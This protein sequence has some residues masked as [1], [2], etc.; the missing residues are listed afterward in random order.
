ME[1]RDVDIIMAY[2]SFWTQIIPGDWGWWDWSKTD[3]RTFKL[4]IW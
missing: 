4:I 3:S 1:R 2:L